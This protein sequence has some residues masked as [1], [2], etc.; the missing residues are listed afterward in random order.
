VSPRVV[1]VSRR[2]L[3]KN[4]WVDWVSEAHVALIMERGLLPVVVP[5]PQE[6]QQHLE[7]YA[8]GMAGLLMVEGGDIHPRH[9]QGDSPVPDLDELD[10]IKDAYEFWFCQKALDRG[11]PIL[12]ICRGMQLLNVI[13]G[14]TLHADVMR[15]KSSTLKHVDKD[16]YD[17]YRHP[18]RVFD[19][20]PLH[21]WY[22]LDQL[23]VNSY[24]HQGIKELA[25]PLRPMA[26]SP[27]GLVEAYYTPSHPFQVG[28][29]FHP[30]RMLDAYEG[31]PRVFD[32]FAE[33]VYTANAPHS[34]T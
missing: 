23:S 2:F 4:K 29:Q 13:Q 10:E 18:V 33:A 16:H 1:V 7:D 11:L 15:E 3:R 24:H 19:K 6:A 14:G 20:T 30:E 31:N 27:D 22:Q 28:L 21:D 12:G 32:A 26:E 5:I 8:E 9:Y 34:G 25:E 17:E